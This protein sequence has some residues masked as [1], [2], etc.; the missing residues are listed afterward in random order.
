MVVEEL[1]DILTKA[2]L[3]C[4]WR[5]Q[6]EILAARLLS[7]YHVGVSAVTSLYQVGGRLVQENNTPIDGR[8]SS[9]FAW[10][11]EMDK[12]TVVDVAS[13]THYWHLAW[14]IS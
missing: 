1:G 8:V 7:C 3:R 4:Q 6:G 5:G 12:I 9:S 10:A 14:L 11:V 13:Y 2:R